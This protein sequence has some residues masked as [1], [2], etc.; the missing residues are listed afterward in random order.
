MKRLIALVSLTLILAGTA[1]S[2]TII[3]TEVVRV[4]PMDPAKLMIVADT[5]INENEFTA[6]ATALAFNSGGALLTPL[7]QSKDTMHFINNNLMI[8]M[9]GFN[10]EYRPSGTGLAGAADTFENN[11]SIYVDSQF[12]STYFFNARFFSL[13]V[14]QLR[15][16]ALNITNRGELNLGYNAFG[17]VR[18][19][20]LDLTSG[21]IRMQDAGTNLFTQG[22]QNFFYYGQGYWDGYWAVGTNTFSPAAY[23]ETPP[24]STPPHVVTNRNYL[25]TSEVLYSTNTLAYVE[26]ELDASGSNRTVRAVFIANTNSLINQKVYFPTFGGID[27]ALQ[28]LTTNNQ[29]VITNTIM[30]EDVFGIYTNFYVDVNGY[31]GPNP[32]YQ[33]WNYRIY[34]NPFF[35]WWSYLPEAQ[36]T[37][38]DA[39]TF[40]GSHGYQWTAYEAIFESASQLL[41]DVYGQDITNAAAR[42]EITGTN[43]LEMKDATINSGSY[44]LL[45]AT[46]HFGGS[47]GA[48]IASPYSD[49]NL[50]VTNGMFSVTNL[51]VPYV[52]KQEG[53]VDLW[54]ARWSSPNG[55]GGTNDYHVLYVEVNLAART[56]TRVQDLKLVVTN[57][58]TPGDGQDSLVLHDVF[59]VTRSMLFDTDRLTIATNDWESAPTTDAGAIYLLNTDVIWANSTPRLQYLTNYGVIQTYNSIH[60]KNGSTLPYKPYRVFHNEGGITNNGSQIY[61][62]DFFNTGVFQASSGGISLLQCVRALMTNSVLAAFGGAINIEA[63]NLIASNTTFYAGTSL[64]L[65]ITNK[66]DDGTAYYVTGGVTNFP[67]ADGVTNKN[68]WVAGRQ[69][70]SLSRPVPHAS[71]LATTI[72]NYND[73]PGNWETKITWA[74]ANRGK[75]TA[76]YT[77]NAGLGRLILDG[78]AQGKFTFKPATAGPSAIYIDH[79]ELMNSATNRDAGGNFTKL[80]VDPNMTVYFGNAVANGVSV[81]EKL[82]GK[83]GGRFVWMASYNDGFYSSKFMV[84]PETGETNRLNIALVE[85]CSLDSDGD[86][87]VNCQ[88]LTPVIIRPSGGNATFSNAARDTI[89]ITWTAPGYSTNE[90]YV[91]DSLTSPE[92]R[93]VNARLEGPGGINSSNVLVLGPTG[94]QVKVT[95]RVTTG[96]P[97]FYRPSVRQQ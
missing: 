80:Q 5:F 30:V 69:G 54:S 73:G 78:G 7:W 42:L 18:G 79:L 11:G 36:P 59:N 50:R 29:G 10:F 66:L 14:P 68:F 6:V 67:H 33:P 95:E 2:Q 40:G 90:L 44:L 19:K 47:E 21:T 35:N 70:L 24:Q 16:H 75:S 82:D 86:G 13:G 72:S 77:N 9:P 32:T 87:I 51:L 58:V 4:P 22:N 43:Y 20:V 17:Q 12:A 88:D 37:V 23:F 53:A 49:I 28:T 52:T 55:A 41:T 89:T 61:A 38:V 92:W 76:G 15:I 26:D 60:F 56:P 1:R 93:L 25:L 39:G 85:S 91:A 46:N 65:A 34:V 27:V 97:R 57:T 81:A 71:L 48:R 45:K 63:A 62:V 3:N 96:A 31:S 74:G 94:G 8:G 64:T 84:N 83:A